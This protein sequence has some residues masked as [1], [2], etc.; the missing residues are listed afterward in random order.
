MLLQDQGVR[1]RWSGAWLLVLAVGLGGCGALERSR[2]A[3]VTIRLG[4]MARPLPEFVAGA[5]PSPQAGWLLGGSP[6]AV[7]TTRVQVW[8]TDTAG[9]SWRIQWRGSGNALSISAPNPA[10]AWIL[11]G[12]RESARRGCRSDLLSTT[13]AGH[14]WRRVSRLPRLANRVQFS[15]SRFGV[16]TAHASCPSVTAN[17]RCPGE[18]LVSDDGGVRWTR[19]LGS[20]G[21]V[22]ATATPT[23]RLWAAELIPGRGGKTGSPFSQV[24]FLSSGDSGRSWHRLGRLEGMDLITADTVVQLAGGPGGLAWASVFD[25]SDCAMHGC[26]TAAV[27]HS[28]DGGRSWKIANLSRELSD[29]CG[30]DS[31]VFSSAPDGTVWAATGENGGACPPPFGV[32]YRHDRSGWQ[33]LPPWQLAGV[34]WL[35]AVDH[36]IAYAISDE[37]AVVRTDDGGLHWTQLLPASSPTGQLQALGERTAVGAQD[38]TDAGAVLRSTDGGASWQQVTKLPGVITQLD[39]P[40]ARDGVALTFQAGR[41]GRA[42]WR[43]WRSED[44]GLSWRA[45][46]GLPPSITAAGIFGPWMSSDGHGVLL[47]IAGTIDW[48]IPASGGVAPVREWTTEDWGAHW[49]ASTRLPGGSDTLDGASFAPTAQAGWAGWTIHSTRSGWGIEAVA[50]TGRI[51]TPLP[52]SPTVNG[53][54]LLGHATGFAWGFSPAVGL[55][56]YRT[57]DDGQHWE[58]TRIHIPRVASPPAANQPLLGFTDPDHGW[59]IVGST[60]WHTSDGGRTWHA[61]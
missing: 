7:G 39:F 41:L 19:V 51:L 59:L 44:G 52:H 5:F 60:T 10:D 8:H 17:S 21:P 26:A 27:Y 47:T 9:A 31:I 34:S 46:P 14:S 57:T 50:G 12:C 53:I 38:A 29:Q 49:R 43:L 15:S 37:T 28:T 35:G 11:I 18:L 30:P 22:F 20:A 61:A 25:Q 4:H 6:A 2:S 16:A 55:S 42:H 24:Q 45:Q 54:Q 48:E 3:N 58:H 23:G 56:L 33:Q 1:R 40:S 32:L 13:D 36:D